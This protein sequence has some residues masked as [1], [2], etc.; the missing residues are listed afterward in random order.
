MNQ[1]QI[2]K[3]NYRDD[4]AWIESSLKLYNIPY[5]VSVYDI[6]G[7]ELGSY[8]QVEVTMKHNNGTPITLA[9]YKFQSGELIEQFL[10]LPEI[11][12]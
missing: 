6:L 12:V 4:L 8:V 2:R 5:S 3:M 10:A 11:Q 1:Y 9:R 7:Y